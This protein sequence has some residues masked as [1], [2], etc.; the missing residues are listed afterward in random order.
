MPLAKPWR[1]NEEHT[2]CP[3]HAVAAVR[4]FAGTAKFVSKKLTIFLPFG[5]SRML[6]T[7]QG[8]A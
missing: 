6:T 2:L 8:R 1:E 3:L 5:P 7:I 4:R